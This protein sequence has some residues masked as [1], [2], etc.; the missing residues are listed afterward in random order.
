MVT[1]Q[2]RV[3]SY[4]ERDFEVSELMALR[5]AA[6]A[7][8]LSLQSIISMVSRGRLTEIIDPDPIHPFKDRRFVLRAEI[9]R[10]VKRRQR[11]AILR[12]EEAID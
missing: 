10:E 8:D 7:L 11:A 6:E 4:E 3:I 9:L 2:V 12:G 5:D 1:L